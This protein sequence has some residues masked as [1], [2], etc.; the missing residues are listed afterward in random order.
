MTK[1]VRRTLKLQNN[2][3][4]QHTVK[5]HQNHMIYLYIKTKKQTVRKKKQDSLTNP[6]LA[7]YK[8]EE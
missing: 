2:P 6:R 1:S 7:S 4:Q 3:Q 5:F 8:V